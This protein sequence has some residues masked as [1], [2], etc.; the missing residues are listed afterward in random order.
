MFLMVDFHNSNTAVKDDSEKVRFDLVPINALTDIA[1]VF[2]FGAKKYS[3]FNW[4]KGK[5]MEWH[6]LFSA[7]LRHLNAFW[8]GED[9]DKE[10]KFHHVASAG[11]NIMMLLSL[12]LDNHGVDDRP[13]KLYP[14]DHIEGN[15]KKEDKDIEQNKKVTNAEEFRENLME[16]NQ[17]LENLK[18]IFGESEQSESTKEEEPC[19]KDENKPVDKIEKEESLNDK[20]PKNELNKVKEKNSRTK[21][22]I[23]NFCTFPVTTKTGIVNRISVNTEHSTEVKN[24]NMVRDLYKYIYINADTKE[25][26]ITKYSEK[27][28]STKEILGYFNE[29]NKKNLNSVEAFNGNKAESEKSEESSNAYSYNEVIRGVEFII[30]KSRTNNMYSYDIKAKRFPNRIITY[31]TNREASKDVI[32]KFIISR[33]FK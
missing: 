10:S 31:S 21:T 15:S 27:P 2:S 5:C 3:D 19:I 26:L 14:T 23:N 24:G 16:H 11:C 18:T 28:L 30:R 32:R 8:D 13:C 1:K 17:F 22:S 29:Y 25:E 7:C 6:R 20:F 4:K 9:F 12:I 33:F